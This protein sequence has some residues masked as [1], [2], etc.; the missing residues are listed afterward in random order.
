MSHRHSSSPATSSRPPPATPAL[1]TSTSSPPQRS[2]TAAR[3][4]D[5]SSALV[6]S[7]WRSTSSVSSRSVASTSS[8]RAPERPHQR[9]AEAAGGTGDQDPAPVGE[10]HVA[11]PSGPAVEGPCAD[12]AVLAASWAHD[13]RARQPATV[14][15]T[16]TRVIGSSQSLRANTMRPVDHGQ[17]R[18]GD[19]HRELPGGDPG[20]P[21]EDQAGERRADGEP[22]GVADH[23]PRRRRG[24]PRRAQ[25]DGEGSLE[26]PA[27]RRRHHLQDDDQPRAQ[28]RRP[29][30]G[31][32]ARRR[33]ATTAR[34]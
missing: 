23:D 33:A 22:G 10:G 28:D 5:Q 26:R 12:V 13:H 9:G 15:T 24:R 3:A 4:A 8:P 14:E 2:S 29:A 17:E 30:P 16:R 20:Q 21:G 32:S 7:R 1:L 34:S 6:T 27:R 25:V 11:D 19:E 31:R 18:Q